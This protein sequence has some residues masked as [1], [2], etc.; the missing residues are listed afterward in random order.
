MS[1]MSY[2]LIQNTA[3]DL[4]EAV[5]KIREHLDRGERLSRD[6]WRYLHKLLDSSKELVALDK[7]YD[8]DDLN[9]NR[10]V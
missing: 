7:E 6:E 1:T 10:P 8:F 2:C 5:E 4:E 3:G 9:P